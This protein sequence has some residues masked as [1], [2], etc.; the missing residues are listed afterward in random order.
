[1]KCADY[2]MIRTED[3]Q[4]SE[5]YKKRKHMEKIKVLVVGCGNM[6]ASHARAYNKLD[7]FEIVGI[8]DARKE[9]VDAFNESVGGNY[10]HFFDYA[11][12]L[13][14]TKPDAVAICTYP[15]THEPLA[16]QAMEAGC[17]VFV[18]KPIASTVEGA[19]RVIE[20]S[21]KYGKKVLVGYILR[22][23]PSWQKFIEL[24]HKLGKPLV[25][26]MNLNQQ[27]H[28]KT[29]EWHMTST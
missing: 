24:S 10:K 27:S 13:A 9:A 17:H 26:R 15:A 4:F 25:M 22:H 7:G 23:H 14:E 20:A 28:G 6:G 18:E 5:T 21:K 29:W 3:A 16:I 12:A 8:V 11:A 2:S 19:E 1:M